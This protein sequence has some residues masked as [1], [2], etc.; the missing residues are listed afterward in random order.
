[1]YMVY[2][3]MMMQVIDMRRQNNLTGVNYNFSQRNVLCDKLPTVVCVSSK[4]KT[5]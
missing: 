5:L 3:T 1:M 4:R 2:L